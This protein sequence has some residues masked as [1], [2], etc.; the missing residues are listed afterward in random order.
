MANL[1]IP[2]TIHQALLMDATLAISISGGKDSQAMLNVLVKWFR[3]CQYPGKIVAVFADL[4][5]IEWAGTIEHCQK[6]C[7]DVG[8][9][10]IVVRRSQGGMVDRWEQRFESILEDDIRKGIAPPELNASSKPHWSSA[11]TRYCTDHLKVQPIDKE[12]RAMSKPHWSSAAQRYCTAELKR[13]P[14]DKDLRKYGDLVI[15]AVG[16]RAEESDNRELQPRY[17]VRTNITTESL[18]EPPRE[19]GKSKSDKEQQREDRQAWA[20]EAFQLWLDGGQKGRLA[21]TWNAIIDWKIG[22]AWQECGTSQVD[23][24]RRVELYKAGNFYEA[25]AGF[26]AHWA[27]ASGNSRL[28]CGLCVLASKSDLANGA[29]HN[30]MVWLELVEMELRSGWLFRK[31]SSLLQ[32]K[33]LIAAVE[34]DFYGRLFAVLRGLGLVKPDNPQ[35]AIELLPAK[36][37]CFYLLKVFLSESNEEN[38]EP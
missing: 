29:I 18:K 5:R 2:K 36:M 4:G 20:D 19:K 38:Y 21:L 8:V 33:E 22:D 10:L 17:H 16:I 35:I 31:D 6:M 24:N 27:Y 30:P 1:T 7:R 25:I 9:E 11:S 37:W 13:G 3:A 26:P 32:F 28:S 23:V 34:K 14:I 12:L 15:C